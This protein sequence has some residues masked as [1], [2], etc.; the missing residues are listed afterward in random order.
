MPEASN[1]PVPGASFPR[2]YR[3]LFKR[4][5][6][7][8][9]ADPV[10]HSA[11]CLTTLARANNLGFPRM[12]LAISKRHARTAVARNRIK[13]VA[14]ESFRQHVPQ[15]AAFDVVVLAGAGITGRSN[16]QLFDAFTRHWQALSQKCVASSSS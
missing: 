14:R 9:F 3:L 6:Q 16:R 7:F 5:Y 15:L 10:R 4:D 8:V 2:G 13:R 12:G 1:A 11:G